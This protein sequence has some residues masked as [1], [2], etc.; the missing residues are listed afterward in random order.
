MF[1]LMTSRGD[2]FTF[3]NTNYITINTNN[4]PPTIASPY[5]STISVSGLNGE[6]ITDLAVTLEDFSHPFPSDVSVILAGP[7]GQMALLMSDVGGAVEDFPV[8]NLIL[9]LDDTSPYPMPINDSL[10]SG[11]FHPT[12]G[13]PL[14]FSF[15]PPCP[16]GNSNASPALSVFDGGDPDGVW[17]LYVVDDFEEVTNGSISGGWSM[18]ISVGIPLKL[19]ATGTNAVLSWPAVGGHTFTPQFSPSLN[20]ATWSNILTSPVL[21]S[22]RLVLTNRITGGSGIYRLLVN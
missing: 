12:S 13:S 22:N 20:N 4:N 1:S 6:V 11:T 15:P 19:A 3:S 17:S 8:T 2:Q 9:T 16:A 18:S 21:I 10:F 7:Q 14:F 5:P